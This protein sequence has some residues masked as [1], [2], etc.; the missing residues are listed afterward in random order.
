MIC[1]CE[2]WWCNVCKAFTQYLLVVLDIPTG[3]VT[4]GHWSLFQ[5]GVSD[6]DC[7]LLC[8]SSVVS[9]LLLVDIV[10][11]LPSPPSME[12]DLCTVVSWCLLANT[13]VFPT[14]ALDS[15]DFLHRSGSREGTWETSCIQAQ[16][17]TANTNHWPCWSP[18]L[19]VFPLSG[20]LGVIVSRSLGSTVGPCIECRLF[21]YF[22]TIVQIW[23]PQK[24]SYFTSCYK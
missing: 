6:T 9:S 13:F 7:S 15:G 14:P 4:S 23:S 19:P 8:Q 24:T 16:L 20:P 3:L 22:L 1:G 21:V 10:S 18:S 5:D 11:S 2:G 12:R 17:V